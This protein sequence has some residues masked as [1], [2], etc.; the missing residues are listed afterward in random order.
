[1]VRH[2]LK[3]LP[4]ISRSAIPEDINQVNKLVN[5]AVYPNLLDNSDY[6]IA[7]AGYNGAHGNTAYLC[8]R[9]S[10]YLVDG[11]M[12]DDGM[13]LTPSG[14]GAWI[15]QYKLLTDTG[16]SKGD[17]VTL[18]VMADGT[19]YSGSATL[20]IKSAAVDADSMVDTDDIRAAVFIPAG[21]TDQIAVYIVIKQT[22]TLTW[23]KLEGGSVATPYVPKG[24]GAELAECMR[25]FQQIAFSVGL[26]RATYKYIPTLIPMRIAP[27]YTL[28]SISA[29]GTL[30]AISTSNL[31]ITANLA[32]PQYFDG[33]ASLSA[34]L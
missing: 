29:S 8:D 5:G 23:T 2:P 1:M 30:P 26:D 17:T 15:I 20:Q 19:V 32:T 6:K 28:Q 14:A 7:Q 31:Y 12:T 18:T 25:Y 34:D 16:L 4:N 22:C 24:Y 10:K 11:S 21:N 9:W 13:L 33:I 27:T 3:I